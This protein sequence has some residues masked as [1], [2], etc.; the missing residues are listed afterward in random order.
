MSQPLPLENLCFLKLGGSL[1]T[2]KDTP[3]TPRLDVLERLAGEI[4][5]AR[6]QRPEM[7]LVIGHGSGSFGHVPAKKYGTREGVS[8]PE[9]WRGF[10]EVWK[11][12]AALNR[13]VMDALHAAGVPAISLPPSAMVTS[14]QGRVLSWELGVVRAALHAGLVPVIYG[15]VIF[16]VVLGGTI[17]STEDLFTYLASALHPRRLLLAGREEGVWADYPHCT[18]LVEQITPA[19]AGKISRVVSGS[20]ATD[21]TGGMES[22]VQ[23]CLALV[24]KL[25]R[26]EIQIFSGVEAGAVENALLGK[27]S[28]TLIWRGEAA[29]PGGS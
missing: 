22:K 26:L 13:L 3:H 4:A 25:P 28:G 14:R 18:Q 5:R 19:D 12:A 10:V 20:T 8:T 17:L 6:Q 1:I 21:V 16:D 15:D 24:G 23:L 29:T 7:C 11:E 27:P 9:E 2:D